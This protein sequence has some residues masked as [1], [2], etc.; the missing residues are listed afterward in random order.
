MIELIKAF[1]PFL[2]KALLITIIV[3]ELCLLCQKEK[4]YKMY[5]GCFLINMITNVSMNL[6]LQYLGNNYYLWLI[7]FEVIVVLVEMLGY[8]IINRNI[9][10]SLRISL[11]CNVASVVL[12]FLL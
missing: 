6:A 2:L 1:Y 12:G 10:K 9:L 5:I 7:I 11:I 4:N 3:E 8:F